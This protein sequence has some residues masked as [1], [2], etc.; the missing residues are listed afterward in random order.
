MVKNYSHPVEHIIGI[1]AALHALNKTSVSDVLLPDT[2]E[3]DN[4]LF[5]QVL[6]PVVF[7]AAQFH[8]GQRLAKGVPKGGTLHLS[9]VM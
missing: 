2:K 6:L 1:W 3:I 8:N 5:L 4:D 7:P 9:E